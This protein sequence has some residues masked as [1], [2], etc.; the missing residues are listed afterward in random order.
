[1]TGTSPSPSRA[2]HLPAPLYLLRGLRLL[3]APGVKRYVLIPFLINVAVFGV[4]GWW[5]SGAIGDWLAPHDPYADS[6]AV[7]QALSWFWIVLSVLVM[8][9]FW[10]ALAWVYTLVANILAAPFNGL[11]AERVEAHLTGRPPP[12]GGSVA[13]LLREIPRT[14]ASEASRIVYLVVRLVP[15]LLLQ[16]MPV[17]N[18]AA[19]FLLFGFGAWVFA[20]EYLDYPMGNHGARFAD[21][22]RQ[23]GTRRMT[24]LGF[25]APVALVSAVP[26]LNLIVMPAAVAGATA[27]WL[28]RFD[29]RTLDG[30]D[31]G[32]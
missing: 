32:T 30:R 19:P 15:L 29:D 4:L 10:L 12:P 6:T 23:A 27:L 25:G 26:L 3:L 2:R 9:A 21:V 22:R 20:L 16:F 5:L 18:V 7:A 13:T 14:L 24:A 1:M 11:L 8:I 31:T 17:V 28:D